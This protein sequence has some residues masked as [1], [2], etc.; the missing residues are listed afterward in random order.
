M[1][2]TSSDT[3]LVSDT[4][5]CTFHRRRSHVLVRATASVDFL[6]SEIRADTPSDC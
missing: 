3:Q 1:Q 5:Y 4:K 2:P 6:I